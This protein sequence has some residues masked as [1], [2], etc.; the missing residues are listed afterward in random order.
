[1]RWCYLIILV[2]GIHGCKAYNVAREDHP[3]ASSPVFGD[4]LEPAAPSA[5]QYETLKPA[6]PQVA[7][8][9][10][11]NRPRHALV[12]GNGR[13]ESSPLKNPVSD[14]KAMA[15]TLGGL[16]FEVTLLTDANLER[17]DSAVRS[18]GARLEPGSVGL[19]FYAGHAV[20]YNGENYLIPI[21]ALRAIDRPSRLKYKSVNAG[22]VLSTMEDAGNGLNLVFLDAC[23]DNPFPGVSR[24]M[25]RGLARMK[26]P[27]GSLL[28]YSTGPDEVALDGEGDDNSPYTQ[29]LLKYLIEPDLSINSILT[30]VNA[31][32]KRM[33][34]QKQVPWYNSSLDEE[35]FFSV[36]QAR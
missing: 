17:M 2:I 27:T 3:R 15:K 19:F 20:Q 26:T 18:F 4:Q 22:E 32:V 1:M 5:L 25:G 8:A 6:T 36:S 24:R 12:I 7:P 13:Y 33:T 9:V 35:F 29:Q 23:R 10:L 11:V 21:D 28:A 34:D 16:G 14:A 30:K 31:E